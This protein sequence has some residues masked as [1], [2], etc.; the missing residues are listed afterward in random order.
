MFA[1]ADKIAR[2]QKKP[3]KEEETLSQI[4]SQC[5]HF[6]SSRF[7][8]QQIL[9][10]QIVAEVRA[11]ALLLW[12]SGRLVVTQSIRALAH[13]PKQLLPAIAQLWP[14]FRQRLRIHADPTSNAAA[15]PSSLSSTLDSSSAAERKRITSNALLSLEQPETPASTALAFVGSNASLLNASK[16]PQSASQTPLSLAQS[17]AGPSSRLKPVFVK[18]L[19]VLE[20][21][22]EHAG[23]F[24]SGRFGSDVWPL[25]SEVLR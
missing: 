11:F 1:G 24:L 22:S 19:E 7:P 25:A 16:Q 13:N 14:A 20:V 17:A 10:L 21:M 8:Q 12:D 6:L 15:M 18:A 2:K 9:V 4:L 5:R 3:S 23:S